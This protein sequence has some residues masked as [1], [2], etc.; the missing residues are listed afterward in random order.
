M[1][2]RAAWTKDEDDKLREWHAQ[3]W[4]ARQ[5]SVQLNKTRNSVIGRLHR[6]GL[7]SAT[8]MESKQQI[9]ARL[10]TIKARGKH[11]KI[12]FAVA[13][14]DEPPLPDIPKSTFA[15]TAASWRSVLA[16]DRTGEP[17]SKHTSIIDLTAWQ[18][19]YSSDMTTPGDEG[20]CGHP[21]KLGSS[22]CAYHHK[23]CFVRAC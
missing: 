11:Q 3:Q 1:S 23:L 8:F 14:V 18:C 4:T 7:K 22:Y 16:Q 12:Q 5:M 6:L 19:H 17:V 10:R 9:A 21:A 13:P 20:F 2:Q 15:G